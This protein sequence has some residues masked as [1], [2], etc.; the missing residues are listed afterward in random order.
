MTKLLDNVNSKFKPYG[1]ANISNAP[2]LEVILH[3]DA[4][5]TVDSNSEILTA[6]LRYIC[7]KA[8][9]LLNSHCNVNLFK[10]NQV[11]EWSLLI[12]QFNESNAFDWLK[13]N[14]V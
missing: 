7:A 1:I 13:S 6:T 2:L 3:G 5:L 14:L 11:I 4:R 12:G 8:M 9:F 10:L